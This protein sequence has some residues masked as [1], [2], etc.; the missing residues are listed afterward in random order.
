MGKRKASDALVRGYII[1]APKKIRRIVDPVIKGHS[2]RAEK[3][4]QKVKKIIRGRRR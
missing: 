4:K 1:H 2:A 3:G